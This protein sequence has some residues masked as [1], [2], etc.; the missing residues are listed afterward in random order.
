VNDLKEALRVR[1]AEPEFGVEVETVEDL[2]ELA[3][4][5]V[6]MGRYAVYLLWIGPKPAT[7]PHKV[8]PEDTAKAAGLKDDDLGM[9][10][11]Y[12]NANPE[13]WDAALRVLQGGKALDDAA[14]EARAAP[15]LPRPTETA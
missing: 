13:G 8:T 12:R 1:G 11:D 4:W 10:S 2:S 15:R 9:I 6:S 14:K 7:W 3:E 5:D